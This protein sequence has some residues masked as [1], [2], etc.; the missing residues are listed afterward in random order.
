MRWG[1]DSLKYLFL[2]LLGFFLWWLLWYFICWLFFLLFHLFLW[3]L[4][5]R[6][7]FRSQTIRS[8]NLLFSHLG[9]NNISIRNYLN[10]L[11]ID[12]LLSLKLDIRV[13][14]LKSIQHLNP[15]FFGPK[16]DKYRL[17]LPFKVVF[18]NERFQSPQNQV[19]PVLW[20]VLER[21]RVLKW[22]VGT[23]YFS[24]CDLC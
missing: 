6:L 23:L 17:L 16:V 3:R 11:I 13:L 10:I 7:F 4:S 2:W 8:L 24:L 1:W 15:V 22:Q 14:H 20:L 12:M 9:L 19:W 18:V 21:Y 5:L